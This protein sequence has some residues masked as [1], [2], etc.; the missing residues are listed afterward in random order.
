MVVAVGFVA[1][2]F[3]A[4]GF[5]AFVLFGFVAVGFVAVVVFV[6]G[7]FVARVVAV[8]FVFCEHFCREGKKKRL[9]IVNRFFYLWKMSVAK[10]DSHSRFCNG[11][12]II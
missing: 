11:L 12:G 2:G 1:V 3:V 5:V 10:A 8:G 6:A 4:V 7:G 9:N